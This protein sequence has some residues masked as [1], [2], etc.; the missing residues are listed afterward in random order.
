MSCRTCD[1]GATVNWEV[2][3]DYIMPYANKVPRAFAIQ[4]A[5][6]ATIELARKSLNLQRDLY[7]DAQEC[8]ND[9]TIEVEDGYNIHMVREVCCGDTTLY[10]RTNIECCPS[11][12]CTFHFDYPCE[13]YLDTAPSC[14]QQDGIYVRASVLPSQDT[15]KIDKWVYDKHAEDIATGAL[16]RLMIMHGTEWYDPRQGGIMLRRWR[17]VM[18]QSRVEQ[19]KAHNAGPVMMKAK[20]WI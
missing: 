20:R 18:S 6:N 2:F 16:S 4:E 19:A 13:L 17:N 1:P 5:R 3:L 12:G 11:G 8:V 9:Y 14:D 7:I 10:P 15:C